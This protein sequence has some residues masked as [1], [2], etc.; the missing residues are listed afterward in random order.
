MRLDKINNL[1]LKRKG[2]ERK[3]Y[4]QVLVLGIRST[5]PIVAASCRCGSFALRG[6]GTIGFCPKK[7]VT[8]LPPFQFGLYSCFSPICACLCGRVSLLIGVV[9]LPFG[10]LSFGLSSLWMGLLGIVFPLFGR[11]VPNSFSFIW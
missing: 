7:V 1:K 10:S 3:H 2:R 11:S 9:L 5:T 6:R 8:P 4:M